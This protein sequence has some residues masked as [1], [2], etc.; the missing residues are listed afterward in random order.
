MTSTV[1]SPA[2]L[3]CSGTP[4]QRSLTELASVGPTIPTPWPI[5]TICWY[6]PVWNRPERSGKRRGRPGRFL[7]LDRKITGRGLNRDRNWTLRVGELFA[8]L[9]RHDPELHGALL[10][11]PEFG[12]PDHELFASAPGFPKEQAAR[13]FLA[14][15][16]PSRTMPGMLA[17]WIASLFCRRT[18]WPRCCASCGAAAVWKSRSCASWLRRPEEIDRNKYVD[19]LASP[20]LGTIRLCLNALGKLTKRPV[21]RELAQ[22][23]LAL[24]RLPEGKAED[25]IRRQFGAALERWTGQAGLG[26]DRDAWTRWFAKSYPAQ[27]GRVAATD[28]VDRGAWTRRLAAFDWGAGDRERGQAVFQKASCAACHSGAQALGP[29]LRGV[30]KRFSRDDL[31]TAILQPSRDISS[32]YR[33]TLLITADDKIYQGIVIYEA[34]DSLLL[35]TGPAATVRLVNQRIVSRK[36]TD[37]SLM[38]AGLLDKLTDREIIDLYAYLKN[39]QP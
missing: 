7:A 31:F 25:P 28:G 3:P 21:P 19:G 4:I 38:P 17:W 26:A 11:D 2:R 32:R 13:R 33:T 18:T 15:A 14:R 9:A 1:K 34:V 6:L 20:Q 24:R 37:I 5:S 39:P 23:I 36:T 16:T 12:R 27:A 8:E 35:Q 22:W 10:Q 30:A 29:D